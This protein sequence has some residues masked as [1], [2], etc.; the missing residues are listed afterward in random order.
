[1]DFVLKVTQRLLHE[2]LGSVGF[3]SQSCYQ[4]YSLVSKDATVVREKSIDS[5]SF[6]F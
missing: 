1:M 4:Q 5:E 6:P 3:S 2:R